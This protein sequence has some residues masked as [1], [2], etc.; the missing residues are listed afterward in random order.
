MLTAKMPSIGY[1]W[2][3]GRLT[4]P[5][6]RFRQARKRWA[7]YPESYVHRIGRVGR[8]GREGVA[9]TL[10][11]SS[12]SIPVL[13]GSEQP[14]E[15][16]TLSAVELPLVDCSTAVLSST[17]RLSSFRTTPPSAA[18]EHPL[19]GSP[20]TLSELSS[21]DCHYIKERNSTSS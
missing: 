14:S 20:A 1:K 12:L 3:T 17:A 9:I 11:R 16:Q 7:H 13:G 8:A 5:V 18:I 15:N 21:R 4:P 10:A 19:A 6:P 2:I